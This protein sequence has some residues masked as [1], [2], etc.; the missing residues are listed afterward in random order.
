MALGSQSAS[1]GG[2][3]KSLIVALDPNGNLAA[4]HVNVSANGAEV[5]TNANPLTVTI[6]NFPTSQS[7]TLASLPALASGTSTIGAVTQASGPWAVSWSGQLVGAT[8]SGAWTVALA[9]GSTV[10]L[11]AGSAAIGSVSV[12]GSVPVTGIFYQAI[13]PVSVAALPLP[14]GAASATNQPALNADGGS[15]AHVTNFPSTQNVSVVALPLPSGAAQ[16]GSDATGIAQPTGG[17]GIRGWLSGIYAKL[18]GTLLV[19]LTTSLPAGAN[20]IGAVSGSG[21]FTIAGQGVT[22]AAPVGPPVS[23]SGI[24]AGGLKQHFRT[25]TFGTPT[26]SAWNSGSASLVALGKAMVSAQQATTAA[27]T[28][29]SLVPPSPTFVQTASLASNLVL[30]TAAG[31]LYACYVTTNSTAGWMMLFDAIAAPAN[32]TVTPKN[33]IYCPANATTEIELPFLTA[34]PFATGI[35]AVFS[36]TGPFTLTASSTVFIK[37]IVQ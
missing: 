11:G 6:G 34:E 2:V 7:V 32:G 26:D 15:L 27:V 23:V 12:T 29:S 20:V 35:T 1:I 37:G 14:A 5:G 28:S 10:T 18:S 31:S 8:Q 13:Q 30:K 9:T 33:C 19:G 36:S 17:A 24:D 25:D 22:G 3:A 16:D 4:A 21:A